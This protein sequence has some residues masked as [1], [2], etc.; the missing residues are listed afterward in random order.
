MK[1]EYIMWDLQSDDD[2]SVTH[3]NELTDTA[4]VDAWRSVP[5]LAAKYWIHDRGSGQ[6]GAILLWDDDRPAGALPAGPALE[7]LERERAHRK[8][9]SVHALI[10]HRPESSRRSLR[11]CVVDAFASTPLSGNPVA[12]F[13]GADSLSAETM[14]RIAAELNLSEVTFVLSADSAESTARIRI[15]TP[16]NELPFAGHPILGTAAAVAAQT[17]AKELAFETAVGLIPMTAE[18]VDDYFRVTMDQP[19]PTWSPMPDAEQ[20]SLLAALGL[21]AS[22]LPIE[23]YDNGPR[24]TIVTVDSIEALSALRPDHRAL[25]E[26]ENMAINCIAEDLD[27][28]W[29]NRMFSPAYGV[30][31]DAATG[32]A[33]GPIAIHLARHGRIEYDH[34]LRIHQGVELGRHSV[35]HA[36][37]SLDA[38]THDLISVQVGGDAITIAH[39]TLYLG[40]DRGTDDE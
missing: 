27:G 32:S 11:Y 13:F 17:G 31:E 12:V 5:G 10:E 6:W 19:L 22:A 15:F 18:A 16:V 20:R 8:D 36:R 37:A 39:A 23:T 26:F 34:D 24:H 14:Q 21:D 30:V 1:L 38:H 35:M 3:L 9:F 40:S 4:A 2:P 7:L 25:S 28:V 33:A 29:R